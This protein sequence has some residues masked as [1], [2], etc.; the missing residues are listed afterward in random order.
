MSGTNESVYLP[1]H[2][3][4]FAVHG[5]TVWILIEG[6]PAPEQSNGRMGQL[7]RGEEYPAGRYKIGVFLLE[8]SPSVQRM[9]RIALDDALVEKLQ[10]NADKE[11]L[12]L[13]L[14]SVEE[15]NALRA[16]S[17]ARPLPGNNLN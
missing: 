9:R 11:R 5:T 15:W 2:L 3:L 12:E 14:P 4:G 6:E 8:V 13:L 10:W 7:D 17:F 16:H 1:K